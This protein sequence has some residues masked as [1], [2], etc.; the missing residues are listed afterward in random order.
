MPFLAALVEEKPP[1]QVKRHSCGARRGEAA[2]S[3]QETQKK[4]SPSVSLES[5]AESRQETQKKEKPPSQETQK[6]RH[7]RH[8]TSATLHFK[9]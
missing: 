9:S 5:A 7:S 1:S 6:N 4:E 3:S 8:S 2:E